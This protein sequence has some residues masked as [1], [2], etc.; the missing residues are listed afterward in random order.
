MAEVED[1]VIVAGGIGSRMLPAS[2]VIAKEMLP[3]VDIPALTH[4]AREAVNAGAKRIHIITSPSKD[5]SSILSDN[6]WACEKRSDID[7][8]LLSPFSDVE[9]MLHVQ[10]VP[11]GFGDAL[12]YALDSIRGPFMVLLGDNILLDNYAGVCGYI[13]SNASKILVDNFNRTSLPCVGLATV[14]DPENYGVVS[15]EGDLI[16]AIVEK[17]TRDSAPSNLVLCG[18]YVFTE[19]TLE[20]LQ[21][22]NF[23]E[24]GELQSIEVQKHWIENNGLV[25]VR[26]EG[27]EW[28]D[29]GVPISWLK[30]QIDYALRRPDLSQEVRDWLNQRLQR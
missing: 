20:L 10:E 14:E 26:L 19:D 17:P 11:K 9:V 18:R 28:Y 8:E 5:F 21:K 15:M 6:S 23:E 24:Y 12:S 4:L 3:L 13:P 22:Y 16:K 29:S 1:A 25:G 27:F 30:S 7:Q 2:S